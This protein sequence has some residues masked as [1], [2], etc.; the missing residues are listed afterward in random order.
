MTTPS[1]PDEQVKLWPLIS[2]ELNAAGISQIIAYGPMR[3][4]YVMNP[5]SAVDQGLGSAENLFVSFLGPAATTETATTFSLP[6]GGVLNFPSGFVGNVYVNALSTGHRF[7]GIVYQPIPN[8]QE[9]TSA[10]PPKGQTSLVQALPQYLYQQYND[11]EDLL[12]FVDAFNGI[13][14][15]YM[16]WL[17][18]INLPVYTGLQGNMLDWVMAGLYGLVR[19]VLP[20]G[21]SQSRGPL[22][23]AIMNSIVLNGYEIDGPDTFYLTTDDTFKRIATWYRWLGD[24]KQFNIRWIKRRVKRFL[25]GVDG[26]PG[27]TDQTYDIGV[28]FGPGGEININLQSI[29]R[30]STFGAMMNVGAMN[31]FALNEFDTESV[32]IPISPLVPIFK[33]AVEAGVLQFP[34]QLHPIV[35]VN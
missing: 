33:A 29:R 35:N 24:G 22:N 19:P 26:G 3:G 11:D 6:P 16:D 1:N 2:V 7:S 5:L 12:A 17:T 13:V 23:T 8:F 9:D 18:T 10:F 32:S 15:S 25:T 28:T 21:L 14:Q 20:Y 30:F 34:F 27:T 31:S 4:G